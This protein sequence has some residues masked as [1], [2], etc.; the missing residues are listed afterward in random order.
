[1]SLARPSAPRVA[2][3]TRAIAVALVAAR[4][5]G[6]GTSEGRLVP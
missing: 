3:A 2:E 5:E 6:N 4:H 1:M